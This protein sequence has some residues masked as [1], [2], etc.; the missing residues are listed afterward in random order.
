M[1]LWHLLIY[2][3]KIVHCGMAA[4]VETSCFSAPLKYQVVK[5]SALALRS[6]RWNKNY[7][8]NIKF[9]NS[10][11]IHSFIHCDNIVHCGMAATVETSWF[12]AQLKYKSG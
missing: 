2:S 1:A 12:S 6:Q 8:L 4:T 5:T 7:N 3:S 10:N 9:Q 11:H